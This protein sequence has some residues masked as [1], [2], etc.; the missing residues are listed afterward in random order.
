MTVI[1]QLE[2]DLVAAADRLSRRRR[3]LPH[4]RPTTAAVVLA[5]LVVVG[6]AG[7]ATGVLSVG[8]VFRG[9]GFHSGSRQTVKE[10]VVASGKV[11]VS[12]P[13]RM[14]VFKTD[15]GVGCLKMKLLDPP[16][17][18]GRGPRSRGYCG[19][20]SGFDVFSHGRKA[21]ARRRGE[22]LLFGRAP[23]KSRRVTLTADGGKRITAPA[24][25]GP[26][27][28][29]GRFWVLAAPPELKRARLAWTDA[30]G[31][32]GERR[33]DVSYLFEGPT[34]RTVVAKGTAPVAGPWRLTIYESRGSISDEGDFY[35][36][37]GLPGIELSLLHGPNGYPA[38]GGGSGVIRNAP[39]FSRGQH[40]VRSGM[41][42]IKDPIKEILLYG[43]APDRAD[44]VRI[45]A[46]GGI[47]LNVKTRKG[48]PGVPG[49]FWFVAT[50]PKLTSGHMRWV[51]T[52]S[53][54]EGPAVAVLPP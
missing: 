42:T 54:E 45:A 15:H 19:Y 4:G 27:R 16:P 5:A 11:R 35:E 6:G 2:R 14:T 50:S 36:P 24:Q 9:E 21:V 39:G 3:L 53:G 8:S 23:A 38:R 41:G 29:P 40:T 32:P 44:H 47:R 12:G 49:R 25:A 51:D 31:R 34:G 13:W 43:R 22:I 18:A 26:R 33:L 20:V 10:T 7:A 30:S 28:V 17:A 46:K 37:E 1:R 48:P 52:S